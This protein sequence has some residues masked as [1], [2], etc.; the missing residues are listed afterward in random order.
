MQPDYDILIAGAGLAGN[1]LALALKDSGLKV[2]II[3]A[4]SREELHDS[5]A[6]DRALAL[7]AGTVNMLQALGVWQGVARAATAI[8]DIHISD[9]GHFGKTRL[10]ARQQGVAALGYVICARDIED[11]VAARV[12]EAGIKQFCPARVAGLMSGIDAVNVSLKQGEQSLNL[13]A[14]LLVGADGGNSSVRKLLDIPQQVTQ[15]GQTALVTTISSSLP[16]HHTAFER[17]TSSGPLA[18]LPQ[19]GNRSAVVWT[20]KQEDAEALM[21][22]G[23]ADFI[24]QLQECFGYRLGELRLAAPRRAFPLSLIRAQTMMSGRT[25][26]IGNAV[27]QLHPVA[28]QGF[29]LGLR[30][31]VQ[32]AEMLL[33]QHEQGLDVGAS[34]LLE[35]YVRLRQQDHDRTIAFTDNVVKIFSSDW[36]ALAAV[37][38]SALTVLDHIPWAKDLLA[39]HAMGLAQRL[40]RI[41][42]KRN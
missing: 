24:A 41:G 19:A 3:E 4:R 17:F 20:R 10:S 30:D 26:I 25:V 13:S 39:R 16:H 15:Y 27:H 33:N 32:L 11:H 21:A 29:N 28:G 2:A 8:T 35:D 14:T 5:P 42:S 34:A 1:C 31:V 12:A 37:R 36:L 7:A 23:E 6:G 40:P 9:R 38:N 18:L 22:G